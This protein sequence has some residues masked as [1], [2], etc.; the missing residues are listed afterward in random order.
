LRSPKLFGPL[1]PIVHR[2]MNDCT[3]ITISSSSQ[4]NSLNP[5]FQLNLFSLTS[6]NQFNLLFFLFHLISLSHISLFLSSFN[7]LQHSFITI[8][9]T[10][11]LNLSISN[12]LSPAQG[13]TLDYEEV[14]KEWGVFAKM[15][16]SILAAL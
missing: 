12:P 4:L 1:S 3:C 13:T 5:P 15:Q 9:P 2:H 16:S 14:C 8:Y 11:S 6:H 10:L 7:S